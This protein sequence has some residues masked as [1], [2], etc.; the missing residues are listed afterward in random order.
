MAVSTKGA[1]TLHQL[2]RHPYVMRVISRIA[3]AASPLSNFYR[4]GLNNSGTETIPAGIRTFSWD[5]FDHTRQLATVRPPKTGPKRGRPQKTGTNVGHL[6]RFHDSLPI[7][8]EDVVNTRPHG[9]RI[10]TLD[11]RGQSKITMQVKHYTEKYMNTRE[12]AVSR[13]FRG[14]FSIKFQG[15]DHYLAELGAGDID[16]DFNTPAAHLD[17][18]A[19]GA[20]DADIIDVP[21]DDPDADIVSQYFALNRAAERITGYPI[22]HT[23]INSTTLGL[24]FKNN[25]LQA[26]GGSAF[27][28][29]ESA[30]GTTVKTTEGNSR[31]SGMEVR[32]RAMPWHTFHVTDNVLQKGGAVADSKADGDVDLIVPDN[33]A[34]FTPD[35]G[36]WAGFAQGQEPVTKNL[37]GGMQIVSGFSTWQMPMLDPSGLELRF[38]DNFFPVPY[39]PE[40]WFYGTVVFTP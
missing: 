7:A 27:R 5:I 38:L 40:A 6:I 26:A 17:Q 1:I 29:F 16:I 10:G 15:E 31:P 21:W 20:G 9:A 14:G 24:L 2:F 39:N 8:W 32:F 36:D 34:I 28:V 3:P 37:A 18:L 30:E 19:V 33:T 11:A 25:V 13:M 22:K 4:M 23:W 35:P 12:W